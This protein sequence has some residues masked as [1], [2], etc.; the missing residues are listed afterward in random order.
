MYANGPS[1]KRTGEQVA[2]ELCGWILVKKVEGLYIPSP[3]LI[4][5]CMFHY[6]LHSIENLPL[7]NNFFSLF[8]ID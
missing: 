3:F 5:H 2:F 8:G 6:S 1:F 7:P 4:F